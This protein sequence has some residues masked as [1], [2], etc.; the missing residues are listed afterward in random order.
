MFTEYLFVIVLIMKIL[1]ALTT[2]S[3]RKKC[4][5]KISTINPWGFPGCSVVNNPPAMQETWVQSLGREDPPEKKMASHSSVL[6]WEIPWTEEPCEL[7]HGVTESR[8]QLSH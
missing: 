2:N 8:K 5:V 6:A 7:V 1:N 3:D 4:E